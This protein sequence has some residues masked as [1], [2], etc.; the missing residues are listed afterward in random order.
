M[1]DE[2]WGSWLSVDRE[3]RGLGY[4]RSKEDSPPV[5][6]RLQGVTGHRL[7]L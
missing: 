7:G 4:C 2:S 1:G 5:P 3:N 6:T